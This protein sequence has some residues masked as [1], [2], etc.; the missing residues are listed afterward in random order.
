MGSILGSELETIYEE[1]AG[2]LM[3]YFQLQGLT[4]AG[5]EDLTQE[6]LFRMLVS[7]SA[8]RRDAALSTWAF[9]IARTVLA[10][11]YRAL[12]KE[13]RSYPSTASPPVPTPEEEVLH[14]E[15]HRLVHSALVRLSPDD[16]SLLIWREY[17]GM[18][19]K[20]IGHMTG[21][22][23]GVVKVRLYRA[24]KR[25]QSAYERL[26]RGAGKS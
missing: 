16:R 17:E 24:H 19:Y 22:P 26:E 1:L 7:W 8:F 2:R 13:T 4:E 9:A 10:D 12:T 25:L 11:H 21:W 5:A 20:D 23:L 14:R 15:E 3:R 6:T 18:S